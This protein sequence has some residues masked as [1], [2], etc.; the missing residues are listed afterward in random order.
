MFSFL[1]FKI[2]GGGQTQDLSLVLDCPACFTFLPFASNRIPLSYRESHPCTLNGA[3]L[4]SLQVLALDP[5]QPIRIMHLIGNSDWFRDGQAT[6]SWT[7]NIPL[8]TFAQNFQNL[9]VYYES[10]QLKGQCKVKA[11]DETISSPCYRDINKEEKRLILDVSFS[12]PGCNCV[13]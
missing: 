4:L 13:P 11:V 2:L 9:V 3:D 6:Q 8:V 5:A 7:S 1:F 12:T 10:C